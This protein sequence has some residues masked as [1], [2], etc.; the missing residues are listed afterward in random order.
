MARGLTQKQQRFADF[1]AGNGLEAAKKAG[2]SGS[3]QVLSNIA[4]AN[5][6][7]PKIA[8]IIKARDEK[9]QK[10]L[11]KKAE[12]E[13]I[14]REF[15]IATRKER[16]DFW[17]RVMEGKEKETIVTPSGKTVK[18][19]PKM[20]DRLKAAELLGKSQADFIDR[21][22]VD[23]TVKVQGIQIELVSPHEETKTED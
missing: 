16:Q 8:A 6:K 15:R 17:T 10:K 11:A 13:G 2:Y 20:S 3:R 23:E 5:L 14:R 21:H 1:Y 18:K 22:I 4:G 19:D 12:E 7:K 9:L